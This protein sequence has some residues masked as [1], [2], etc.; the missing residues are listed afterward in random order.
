MT[1]TWK[2]R[3]DMQFTALNMSMPRSKTMLFEPTTTEIKDFIDDLTSSERTLLLEQVREKI[4]G[5]IDVIE[6][7]KS[8][9]P[10]SK[11]DERRYIYAIGTL[12]ELGDRIATLKD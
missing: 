12:M 10:V 6:E 11:E 9:A 5:M 3:F 2:E 7:L 8:I 4:K 1:T